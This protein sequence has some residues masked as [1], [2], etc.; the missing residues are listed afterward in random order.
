[1]SPAPHSGHAG[2]ARRRRAIVNP[3]LHRL[4]FRLTAWYV[5]VFAL[6]L[7]GFGGAVFLAIGSEASREL[8][9]SLA[10]AAQDVMR[11]AAIRRAEA[12]SPGPH[13]DALEEL[14]IPGRRLYLF[15]ARAAPIH[16]ALAPAWLVAM[17]HR[18]LA[19]GT[20]V[21]EQDLP[22]QVTW[23][24]HA[25]R[26]TL[27][28]QTLVAVAAG[29]ALEL[30]QQYPD[31]LFRFAIAALLAL[32]AVALGGWWLARKSVEPVDA[33]FARMRGFMADAAH[34]LRTPVAV[35]R[36]R[37]EV[38][39]RRSRDV[40]DYR[41]ALAAVGDEARRL[42]GI[43]DDLLTIAR[44]DAGDW[45]ISRERLFLDDL[46]LD[47]AAAARALGS[48]RG[49]RVEV[50]GLEEAPLLGDAVLLRQLLMILLDNAVKFT[51]GGGEVRVGVQH[52]EG[53]VRL[54]VADSGPGIPPEQLPQV[55]ER[56]F[57]GD[58]A[59]AR[60]TGAGLGLS[61]ARWIAQAHSGTIAITSPAGGG[62]TAEVCFPA[63]VP[64]AP[65]S[66]RHA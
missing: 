27:A 34:E 8:D 37:A 23:R 20:V 53:T 58:P 29:D 46:V 6:I 44:A 60:G 57:R 32:G 9:R 28:G 7:A 30:D 24:V 51:P 15:D 62:T 49:V 65:A 52:R 40:E 63:D 64:A 13:L 36:S 4:R 66:A 3:A 38:A 22:D 12:A 33:A 59:R 19:Q 61:I 18:A 50:D 56:F 31:L 2:D 1:M 45:P 55:F 54:S 41:A 26:F 17:A 35:L 21:A 48:A 14:H 42:G 11:A 47:A 39:L 16:P 10:R 25:E 5:A 43:V